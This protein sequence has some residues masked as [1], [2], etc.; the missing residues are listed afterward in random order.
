MAAQML[1]ADVPLTLLVDNDANPNV[2]SDREW[3]LLVDNIQQRGF[4]DPIY[5]APL[6]VP[7]FLVRLS[8][9]TNKADLWSG[10]E[11]DKKCFRIVGGH[12][13]R[14]AAT[15]LQMKTVPC[16]IDLDPDFDQDQQE[17]QM[18]RHNVIHGRMSP[19]KFLAL[20]NKH[21]AKHGPEMMANMFGFAEEA[22]LKKLI[23]QTE[24]TLPDNM[25]KAFAEAAEEIH[26]I[27]DLTK[28]LN[29]LYTA[30]G[31]TIPYQFMLL[32]YG[33]QK[34]IWIRISKKTYE[35]ILLV[36]DMC[37]Q[38]GRTM[39]DVLGRLVQMIALG[40]ADALLEE[41]VKTTKEVKLPSDFQGLPTKENLA[42]VGDIAMEDVE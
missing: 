38:K 5:C 7:D 33:G 3:D 17:L 13:R 37:V 28:L 8:K 20:Y 39:D 1:R 10:M 42:K 24:K 32:D 21:A 11:A 35:A 22:E 25:K 15:F 27:D 36:G 19:Q 18:V 26:T 29:H 9:V 23:E 30:F 4:T 12:H 14:R 34:S 31:D 40:Q 2:M 16:T 41:I 6:D